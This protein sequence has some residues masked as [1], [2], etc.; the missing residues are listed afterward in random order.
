MK[1]RRSTY[2]SE[3]WLRRKTVIAIL[4]LISFLKFVFED[5][6]KFI[7]RQ[8][9]IWYHLEIK[10]G[11]HE[12]SPAQHALLCLDQKKSLEC[13]KQYLTSVCQAPS[14]MHL[15]EI[16]SG[17]R[18]VTPHYL[19]F[20]FSFTHNIH[21]QNSNLY[22]LAAVLDS[23]GTSVNRTPKV[24]ALRT[25]LCGIKEELANKI[26]TIITLSKFIAQVKRLKE[27]CRKKKKERK[28][29]RAR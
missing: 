18:T 7:R 19:N 25:W 24:G 5:D 11:K 10:K 14:K 17:G 22:L 28:H 1:Y 20:S 12:M 8:H 4:F 23:Q 6:G 9:F 2:L 29:R 26:M 16:L 27:L 15:G 3:S 13:A 21:I